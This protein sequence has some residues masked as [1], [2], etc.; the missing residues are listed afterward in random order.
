M[1]ST[2]E[3]PDRQIESEPKKIKYTCNHDKHKNLKHLPDIENYV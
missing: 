2:L 1:Q 3:V